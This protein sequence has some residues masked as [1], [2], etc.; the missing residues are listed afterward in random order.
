MGKAESEARC[1][2]GR[3]T[4][5]GLYT[6]GGVDYREASEAAIWELPVPGKCSPFCT[7]AWC[8]GM[9]NLFFFLAFYAWKYLTLS[10][11]YSAH[12]PLT[13]PNLCF[14]QGLDQLTSKFGTLDHIGVAFVKDL[15]FSPFFFP[16][17]F[18]V[19]WKINDKNRENHSFSKETHMNSSKDVGQNFP[20]MPRRVLLF[21]PHCDRPLY[22]VR[23]D[24][25]W[26]AADELWSWVKSA[27][28]WRFF[29]HLKKSCQ[30]VL[31]GIAGS[32]KEAPLRLQPNIL[33]QNGVSCQTM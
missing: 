11:T 32:D 31:S 3:R 23:V 22:E 4:W 27:K 30:T 13:L 33:G 14:Q 15:R 26:W 1:G 19:V 8:F 7:N 28:P 12:Q 6:A 18:A 21:M 24:V 25:L 16:K 10:L 9:G 29:C 5:V 20:A 17:G 2:C